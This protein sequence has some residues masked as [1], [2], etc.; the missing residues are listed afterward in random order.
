MSAEGYITVVCETRE[1][2]RSMSY[3]WGLLRSNFS[4]ELVERV[5]G[6]KMLSNGRGC[7]FDLAEEDKH[8]IQSFNVNASKSSFNFN[9][10]YELPELV[11][12]VE[13]NGRGSFG[14]GG[15]YG[16]Y[17]SGGRDSSYGRRDFGGA[18]T[19]SYG[20]GMGQRDSSRPYERDGG[21]YGGDRSASRGGSGRGD[22]DS[23]VFIGNLGFNVE[24]KDLFD[25]FSKNNVACQDAYIIKSSLFSKNLT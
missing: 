20:G 14:R 18:R 3:V 15:S 19:G 1:E 16:S 13:F 7:A 17:G 9:F 8:E 23:K 12:E 11:E 6:M 24:N 25:F 22:E 21:R 10:P 5:K 2:I 4:P